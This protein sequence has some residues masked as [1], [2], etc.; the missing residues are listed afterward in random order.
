MPANILPEQKLAFIVLHLFKQIAGNSVLQTKPDD[1]GP[2]FELVICRKCWVNVRYSL[3]FNGCLLQAHTTTTLTL[4]FSENVFLKSVNVWE[5]VSAGFKGHHVYGEWLV[6]FHN[7]LANAACS[8]SELSRAP[9]VFFAFPVGK[10]EPSSNQK[11]SSLFLVLFTHFPPC[12]YSH[13][14]SLLLILLFLHL[15]TVSKLVWSQ[16]LIPGVFPGILQLI[17]CNCEVIVLLG[18]TIYSADW[19]CL[20]AYQFC[21]VLKNW[22]L[23]FFWWYIKYL[24]SLW[25]TLLLTYQL[26][27]PFKSRL[28]SSKHDNNWVS[29]VM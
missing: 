13:T 22:D 6:S 11:T 29:N 8:S 9:R 12:P 21:R 23:F 10:W 28:D 18:I 24:D 4:I 1:K 5:D 25:I 15:E 19:E 26:M 2:W 27:L 20:Q 16:F 7:I 14:H 3:G 17:G